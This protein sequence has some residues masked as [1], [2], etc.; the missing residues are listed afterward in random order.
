MRK[1]I[2][3]LTLSAAFFFFRRKRGHHDHSL[4]TELRMALSRAHDH[5][6]SDKPTILGALTIL[7]GKT[8][9]S[10][11]ITTDDYAIT[12]V[13]QQSTAPAT[14]LIACRHER[15]SILYGDIGVVYDTQ[16]VLVRVS[17]CSPGSGAIVSL[18]GDAI[19]PD[20]SDLLAYINAMIR[21]ECLE[22]SA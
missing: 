19:P 17:Y 15:D 14:T 4:V 8:I 16:G 9:P 13:P 1:W 2:C 11:H 22:R 10:Y 18:R 20:I 5:L 21:N 12:Y 3:I 6:R 7:N